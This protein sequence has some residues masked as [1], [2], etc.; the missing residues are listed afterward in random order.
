MGFRIPVLNQ[1]SEEFKL[2]F[3][4]KVNEPTLQKRLVLVIV[5]TA[6]LLDNMLY[7]VIVP[8][9]PDYLRDVGAY[10]VSYEDSE[11][12]HPNGTKYTKRDTVYEGEDEALG[13]LFASK[14]LVQI[15]INPMSGTLIDRIGYEW[16]MM[17]GLTVMFFSTS[18]FAA[19]SSYGVLFAARSLQGLGSAFAD[20]SGSP[21]PFHLPPFLLMT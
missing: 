4:K 6:L 15:F 3:Y 18:I 12:V 2:K 17:F 10:D 1:D 9:I 7:M 14:A 20:T 19:G 8:I 11:E 16:P 21:P 13:Y 5:S